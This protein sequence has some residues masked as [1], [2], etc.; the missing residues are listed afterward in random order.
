MLN[1]RFNASSLLVSLIL[2]SGILAVIFLT[3]EQLLGQEELSLAYYKR[4]L[5]E[6]ILLKNKLKEGEQCQNSKIEKISE[7][8]GN[9]KYYYSCEKKSLFIDQKPPKEKYITFT[10]IQE[11]LDLER[12]GKYVTY[13]YSLSELPKSSE[14]DPQIVM[15]KNKI[16]EKL[17]KDFYGIIIT[18]DYFDITGKGKIYGALYSSFDNVREER[19]LT[20]K[21]SVIANLD[22]KF[23]IWQEI[24][25]SRNVLKND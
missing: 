24:P 20:F 3:K 19:N 18:Q 25:Y 23:S 9:R 12:Y 5:S 14:E 21:K 16:D 13:I 8:I 4:Y 2:V 10:D 1:K 6:K 11:F 7:K 22:N 15:V 17:D